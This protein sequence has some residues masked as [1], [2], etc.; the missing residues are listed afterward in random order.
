MRKVEMESWEQLLA[1]E[2]AEWDAMEATLAADEQLM[3]LDDITYE[4]YTELD[5]GPHAH[6][7]ELDPASAE[8]YD[9]RT[10]A[11]RSGPAERWRHFGH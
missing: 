11:W 2:V 8:D 4:T 3:L 6:R 10:Q 1:A 5:F 7:W 9:E